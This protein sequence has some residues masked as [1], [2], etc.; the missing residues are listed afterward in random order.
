MFGKPGRPPEDRLA[1]QRAIYERVAPL[2]LERGPR[3]LSMRD[4]AR[5]AHLSVGGLY[6]YFPTKRDLVLHGLRP[7]PLA[8]LCADF[9]VQWPGGRRS[10]EPQACLSAFVEHFVTQVVF[11]RPSLHAALELGSD[12]F[13]DSVDAGITAGLD[14][15][16]HF[17]GSVL[18]TGHDG[19]LA[20]LARSLRRAFFAAL[21]DKSAGP[22]ALR[23]E[24]R[25]LIEPF[26]ATCQRAS[27]A[28]GGRLST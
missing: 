2:V 11:V 24:L 21:L 6:H 20:V 13:W 16:G 7:E 26:S 14:D 18:P 17:L 12:T 25:A 27:D 8:R 3:A 22:E 15:F 4:A 19:D 10:S 1:R 23:G 9:D 28:S 5:A